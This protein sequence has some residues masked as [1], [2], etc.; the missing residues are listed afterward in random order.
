MQVHPNH[1]SVT[2]ILVDYDTP[3][4]RHMKGV[5]TAWLKLKQVSKIDKTCHCYC[6]TNY[7]NKRI[8]FEM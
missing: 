5:A 6:V 4:G 7:C 1:I 2:A 8:Q 3:T